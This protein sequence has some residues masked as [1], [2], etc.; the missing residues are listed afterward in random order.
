MFQTSWTTTTLWWVRCPILVRHGKKKSFR[1]HQWGKSV[2]PIFNKVFGK[3]QCYH[4]PLNATQEMMVTPAW[5]H[6]KLEC[7]VLPSPLAWTDSWCLVVS[8][9]QNW[10]ILN[11]FRYKKRS[12][13]LFLPLIQSKALIRNKW[14]RPMFFLNLLL[15]FL[16]SMQMNKV[17][18]EDC[19]LYFLSE[20]RT[21]DRTDTV[22]DF[23]S[24]TD[25]VS[26]SCN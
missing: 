14:S 15:L 18:V 8:D 16:K 5:L 1:A 13:S 25:S 9:F 24:S 7:V 19:Q 21:K 20:F 2:S 4:P 22:W 17:S 3:T 11:V 12:V 23:V 26:I 6:S 10:C